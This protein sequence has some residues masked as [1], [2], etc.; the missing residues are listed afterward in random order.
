MTTITPKSLLNIV[1]IDLKRD[2]NPLLNEILTI[3]GREMRAHSGTIMLVN[4]VTGELEMGATFGLPDDYIEK[5]YSEGVPITTSPS[6][7]VL[8][9]GRY[10]QVPN[11][12]EEPRDK[13]W[14]DLGREL[15][16][17]AQIVMPMKGKDEVIGLLNVYMANPHEFTESEIAFLTIAASQAAAVIENARLY[18]RIEN[19]N[20][21]LEY[22]INERKRVEAALREKKELLSNILAGSAVGIGVVEDR[23]L[24]WTNESMMKMFGVE[25]E[26]DYIGQ[27]AKILYA[28]E[29]EY[30]RVGQILHKNRT[31]KVVQFDAQLKRKDGSIFYGCILISFLDLSNPMKKA[32]AT[33][34]DISWRKHA[35]VA[36][37]R[38]EERLRVLFEYA[39]NAYFLYD[40]EGN[41]LDVNKAAESISGY[42]KEEVIGKNLFNLKILPPEQKP[43][44]D[45]FLAK[46]VQ[47][48]PRD[49]GERIL[50]RKEGNKVIVELKAFPV[51]IEDRTLVLCSTLDITARKRAEEAL[52]TKNR[53]LVPEINNRRRVEN[54]LKRSEQKYKEITDFLPDQI[55]EYIR[56]LN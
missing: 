48:Q 28:S 19:K 18:T 55:Y 53:E 24:S 30:E 5:V 23:K 13:P 32:I 22:E 25:N 16:I 38:S 14:L 52:V 29:E 47:G 54:A 27:S 43:K 42:K 50:T 26:E 21:E 1:K 37:K 41:L 4:E 3:A 40:L 11:I 51:K 44:A 56:I 33:I 17:S 8:E 6:G 45:A 36:L 10:Y 2:L 46:P 20:V 49:S 12:F 31:D 35:E 15:G 7:V 34:L 39:P 9:A